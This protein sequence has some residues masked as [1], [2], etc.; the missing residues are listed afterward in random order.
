[1]EPLI[2]P[3]LDIKPLE[4]RGVFSV[5]WYK[6]WDSITTLGN[7]LL[8]QVTD[9]LGRDYVYG[10]SNLSNVGRLLKVSAAKTVTESAVN[11]DGAHVTSTEPFAATGAIRAMSTTHVAPAA[12]KSVEI[13]Y[14]SADDWGTIVAFDRD[15]VAHKTMR[16]NGSVVLALIAGVEKARVHS[17]GF[18]GILNAAPAYPLDV[19][20]EVRTDTE[21][22]VGANKVVGARGAALT[23]AG[24]AVGGTANFPYDVATQ[25]VITNLIALANNS[26]TRVAE[27]EARLQA[28]GL[29]T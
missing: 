3:R 8:I 24:S 20:G 13:D 14:S 9:L 25:T 5:L 22:R 4:D 23:G 10:G 1:M 12:G 26:R 6:F 28:H 2:T 19:T 29:I 18:T 21:Y 16:V 11:D 7:Y 27:L 17:N 15:A